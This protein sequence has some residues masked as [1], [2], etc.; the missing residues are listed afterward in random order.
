VNDAVAYSALENSD[1]SP[2]LRAAWNGQVVGSVAAVLL[3]FIGS[4]I[5]GFRAFRQQQ[6]QE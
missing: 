3:I 1:R 6:E 2:G 5:Y 4:L